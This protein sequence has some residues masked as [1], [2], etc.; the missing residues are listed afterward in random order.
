MKRKHREHDNRKKMPIRAFLNKRKGGKKRMKEYILSIDQ[1]TTSIRAIFFNHDGD[2][3]S[4]FAK[5]FSQFYPDSGWVE[6]DPLEMW[7]VTI[8]VIE[9]AMK[10][11]NIKEEEIVAIGITNQRETTIVWDKNTGEPVYNA[12]V[13]QDRRTA[14]YCDQLK[15]DN[16]EIE[17]IVRNKTGLMIDSYFSG[18]KIKWILDNV[19]GAREKAEKGSL[20]FGN[21]DAWIMWNLTG[22]KVHATDYS[23]ASR[24]L[25]FNINELKWMKNS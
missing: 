20:L 25:I 15:A 2:V 16:P 14:E 7:S 4:V 23:N 22:G 10:K 21:V 8:E 18:T 1:G 12:I 17:G 24:T 3:V 5:E 6:Q 13:W 11:S 9:K 19:D